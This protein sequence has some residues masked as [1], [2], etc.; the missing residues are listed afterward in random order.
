VIKAQEC[1]VD[2]ASSHDF[3]VVSFCGLNVSEPVFMLLV[4]ASQ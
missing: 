4:S 2:P 3:S 1:K